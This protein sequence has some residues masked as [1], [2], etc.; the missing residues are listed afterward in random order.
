MLN[1]LNRTQKTQ[2]CF[3]EMLKSKGFDKKEA[4]KLLNNGATKH[5]SIETEVKYMVRVKET[6]SLA[7]KQRSF[8]LNTPQQNSEQRNRSQIHC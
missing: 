2:Y 5:V 4:P 3:A 1:C 7:T 8:V 6:K